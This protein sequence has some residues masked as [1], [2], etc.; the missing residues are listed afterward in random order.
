MNRSLIFLGMIG[1]TFAFG[2]CTGSIGGDGE[3]VGVSEDQLCVV[4]TAIRRL[5][6]YEY[7]NTVRDL[8]GDT[9]QPADILPPEEEVQGFNNQAAALTVSDLLAEQYMKVAEGV[10]ERAVTNMGTLIGGCDTVATP[11]TCVDAFITD[12]GKKA[13]RRPLTDEE[14]TRMRGLFDTAM[15]DPDLA[16]FEMG[17]RFIIE[18]MLQSPHF[19]YRPEFGGAEPAFPN[20]D[21]V[22]L[23]DWE[24]ATKLSYMLWNTMPDDEL[25]GLAELGQLNTQEQV[26]EQARRMLDDPRAKD[27]IRN[28]H[29]QWL[30]LT[31]IDTLSK[32]A[33]VYPSYDDTLRPLW[34]EEIQSFIEYVIF[35]DDASLQTLLTA[36]YSFMNA[37]L[38][39]F[40]GADVTESVTGTEFVKVSVDPARRAGLLTSGALMATLAK[41]DQSS[42]VYRGKFVREQLMCDILPLPPANLVIEPPD[43]DSSKT[44]R[45]QFEAIGSNPD[46]ASCHLLMNPIGFLFENYDG[47]G[48]WRDEQNNKPID[49]SG[50]VVSADDPNL[51]GSFGSALEF[52]D[53]LAQSPQVAE[54][55]SSQW[56]RFAYN[57]TVTEGDACTIDLINEAFAGSGYNIKELLVTLTQTR[58][59]LYRHDVVVEGGDQ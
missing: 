1:T 51:E 6:R 44:T 38:A 32:N 42:P 55:V 17:I 25:F 15:A 11:D 58:A 31:Q 50:D 30:L 16:T 43:L 56:F 36:N 39:T 57:R 52:A 14:V 53:V 2:A 5:T 7:N 9:T 46:C 59:F 27:A 54:C 29:K 24:L 19:L 23:D 12:F 13:F 45:E 33:T 34:E 35:E 3:S 10:S 26:A 4:D 8:F 28:F 22:A 20:T 40:Y 21:V 37:E 18:A 41:G 49:S 48:R 47:I